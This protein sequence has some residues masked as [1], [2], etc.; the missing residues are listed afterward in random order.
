MAS[1]ESGAGGTRSTRNEPRSIERTARNEDT[2][3][4]PGPLEG[5]WTRLSFQLG[6]LIGEAVV[7]LRVE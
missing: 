4:F 3:L 6:T 7:V 1:G 2:G 5:E